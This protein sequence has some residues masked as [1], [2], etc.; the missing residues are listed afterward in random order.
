MINKRNIKIE[1]LNYKNK[2]I[3]DV[4]PNSR[5]LH[6]ITTTFIINEEN[7]NDTLNPV[8]LTKFDL[9]NNKNLS[10]FK[11]QKCKT[12]SN[13]Y[14]KFLF[15]PPIGLSSDDI[16]K[17]YDINSIEQI[18]EMIINESNELSFYTINRLIN[19]WIRVN[20]ETLK[21]YNNILENIYFNLFQKYIISNIEKN[22]KNGKIDFNKEIKY[23]IDYW[24]NKKKANEFDFNLYNDFIIYLNK[25][26]K[27]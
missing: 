1:Y 26:I 4:N 8:C 3:I 20:F 27:K 9:D 16:L 17:L 23:Y 11:Y 5:M 15:V 25:K 6:P 12:D 7:N 2:D 21:K 19:C 22:I 24:I 10:S 14:K 18:N 13:N